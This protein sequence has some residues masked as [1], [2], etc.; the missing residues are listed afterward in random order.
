MHSPACLTLQQK[1]LQ[2][3]RTLRREKKAVEFLKRH[4][5][6]KTKKYMELNNTSF[7]TAIAD[8]TELLKFKYVKKVGSYRGAYYVLNEDKNRENSQILNKQG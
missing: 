1:S 7:G 5:S 2:T 4:K 8:I 6:L 3:G